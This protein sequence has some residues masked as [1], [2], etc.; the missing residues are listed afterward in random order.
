MSEVKTVAAS[1]RWRRR[2]R[3]LAIHVLGPIVAF[4]L[5]LWIT[6]VSHWHGMTTDFSAMF[7]ILAVNVWS[8]WTA[9]WNHRLRTSFRV[10][11]TIVAIVVAFIAMNLIGYAFRL[12]YV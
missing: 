10:I 4:A 1:E 7:V 12:P 8:I 9:E 11:V 2:A 3:A 5:Y 6:S